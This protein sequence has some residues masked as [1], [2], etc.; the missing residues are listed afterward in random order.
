MMRD[1]DDNADNGS[2]HPV[3]VLFDL[4]SVFGMDRAAFVDLPR[5]KQL[6]LKKNVGLFWTLASQCLSSTR[7]LQNWL[8]EVCLT[9]KHGTK[10]FCLYLRQILT[11]FYEFFH[12]R[13]RHTVCDKMIVKIPATRKRCCCSTM[14]N[15][16]D[17]F[18]ANCLPICRRTEI[19]FGGVIHFRCCWNLARPEAI[20]IG[21]DLCFTADVFF[22]RKISKVRGPIVAKFCTVVCS[23]L[24]FKN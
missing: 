17:L 19:S 7:S 8:T 24:N 11:D 5:W 20:A 10:S 9:E 18:V 14:W 16:A 4:Q 13:T 15:C 3:V 6:N 21:A 1:F 22:Q 12:C 23:R 2:Q